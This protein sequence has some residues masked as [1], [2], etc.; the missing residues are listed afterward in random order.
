[1]GKLQKEVNS[2]YSLGQGSVVWFYQHT[3]ALGRNTHSLTGSLTHYSHEKPVS[4][5][6][7]APHMCWWFLET[8]QTHSCILWVI[9][10]SLTLLMLTFIYHWPKLHRDWE[11]LNWNEVFI[12]RW[13]VCSLVYALIFFCFAIQSMHLFIIHMQQEHDQWP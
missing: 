4:M 1:M 8:R 3:A 6:S 11:H 13:K 10:H 12:I 2:D 5:W 9:L 7:C